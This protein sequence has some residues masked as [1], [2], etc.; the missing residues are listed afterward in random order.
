M[1][2]LN[3]DPVWNFFLGDDADLVLHVSGS[4]ADLFC[5]SILGFLFGSFGDPVRI[6]YVDLLRILMAD[7]ESF[8]FCGVGRSLCGS[9]CGSICGSP[10]RIY[11]GTDFMRM[12]RYVFL[13]ELHA[14][15][16]A[17]LYADLPS[18]S[19]L[20]CLYYRCC[21]TIRV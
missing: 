2:I 12:F 13:T 1:R 16:Y 18:G 3:A 7:F 19:A 21:W 15:Q 10:M 14:E 8:V 5:G 17:V 6:L 11:P 9:D 4:Y 20:V